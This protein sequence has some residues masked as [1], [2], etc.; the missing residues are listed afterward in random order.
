MLPFSPTARIFVC[1]ND[2]DF[3]K[4]IDGLSA[5]CRNQLSED[6]MSGILFVF[7]NRRRTTLRILMYDGILALHQK[8]V[9]RKV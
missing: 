1:L 4:G 8:A 9:P 5:I 6:P 3:R 7:R 2:V